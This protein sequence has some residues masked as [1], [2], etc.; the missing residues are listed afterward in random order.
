MLLR[1]VFECALDQ[2]RG[3]GRSELLH[4]VEVGIEWWSVRSVSVLGDDLAP[5][6][7]EFLHRSQLFR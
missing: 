7:G 6:L 5:L 2:S 3:G 4:L 1:E